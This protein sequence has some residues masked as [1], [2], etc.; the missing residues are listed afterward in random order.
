MIR[1]VRFFGLVLALFL[2]A[3]LYAAQDYGSLR[4][5]VEPEPKPGAS[6]GYTEYIFVVQNRSTDRSHDVRLTMPRTH[7]SHGGEELREVSRSFQVGPGAT[8]RVSL[9]VPYHPAIMGGSATVAIDGREQEETLTVHV[10]PGGSRYSSLSPYVSKS[11]PGSGFGSAFVLVSSGGAR[12]VLEPLEK[13]KE[14]ISKGATTGRPVFVNLSGAAQSTQFARSEIPIETWST[15]WLGY[16][17]YDG[18]IVTADEMKKAPAGVQGVLIQYVQCGGSLLVLGEWAVP[19]SW[20]RTRDNLTR[21]TRYDAGFGH[22]FIGTDPAIKQWQSEPWDTLGNSWSNTAGPWRGQP[23]SV[24]DAD[25][26]FPVVENLGVPVKGLF[27]LMLLFAIGIGPVNLWWLARLKRRIWMLWTIPAVSLL[28]IFAVFGYMIVSEGWHGHLRTE[29]LTL[30][31]EN[32]HHAVTIGRTGF[33]SPL[34]PGGGLHFSP[35]TELMPQTG[36]VEETSY[37]PTRGRGSRAAGPGSS[38]SLDWTQE[39]HLSRGWINARIPAHFTVRKCETRRE[40]VTIAKNKDGLLTVVNG[41][42]ADM[43]SFELADEK[44]KLYRTAGGVSPGGQGVL[45]PTGESI[46]PESAETAWR[47][48]Y[49]GD[50]SQSI[51]TLPGRTKE[52]LRPRTYLAVLDDAP[53]LEDGLPSTKNRKCTSVVLGLLKEKDD[54]S[55]DR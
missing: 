37:Y 21:V 15:N 12:E 41:L 6:H 22:C 5:T 13:L 30:L 20:K 38:C 36:S 31:D 18:I 7:D 14:K 42:G 29:T 9:L 39:Q 55:T 19:A 49:T 40:R 46:A 53:F 23:R 16:S 51:R 2:C 26:T 34:T 8:A 24:A 52:F 44:G 25:R 27:V 35:E 50:W 43:K 10:A 3:P 33:Y 11:Y 4:I 17:R 1:T 48:L 32:S 45:T 54:E 28:T 47:R